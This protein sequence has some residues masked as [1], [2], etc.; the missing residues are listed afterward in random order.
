MPMT[1]PSVSELLK[2]AECRYTLVV[3]VSKRARQL[4]AGSQPL[5]DTREN[6]AVSIAVEEIDRGLIDHEIPKETD[7]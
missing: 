4:V 2:H 6:K 1:K 5:I 3:K 7:E